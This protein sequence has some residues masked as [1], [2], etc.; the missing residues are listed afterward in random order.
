MSVWYENVRAENSQI[1]TNWHGMCLEM[2]TF[3]NAAFFKMVPE[4]HLIKHWHHATII[5]L[6]LCIS[7]HTYYVV[8]HIQSSG[9][10]KGLA[11]R[12]ILA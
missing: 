11:D 4:S 7:L 10:G 1:M 3:R 6:E 12:G 5:A 9:L 2:K 8:D